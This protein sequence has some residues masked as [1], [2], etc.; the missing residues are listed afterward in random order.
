MGISI[1]QVYDIYK[2]HPFNNPGVVRPEIGALVCY[3][4]P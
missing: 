4:H 1:V 2:D 3:H